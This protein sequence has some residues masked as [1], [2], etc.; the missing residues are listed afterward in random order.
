MSIVESVV[1]KPMVVVKS[2][3]RILCELSDNAVTDRAMPEFSPVATSQD[4]DTVMLLPARQ[5]QVLVVNG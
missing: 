3:M 5:C 4:A 1:L 2:A